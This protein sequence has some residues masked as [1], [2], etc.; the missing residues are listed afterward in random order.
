MIKV[1]EWLFEQCI[2]VNMNEVVIKILQGSVVKKPSG[3]SNYWYISSCYKFPIER[4]C[5]K[6]MKI[7]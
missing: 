2:E 1:N 3:G 6:I 4:I 5:G 7:G